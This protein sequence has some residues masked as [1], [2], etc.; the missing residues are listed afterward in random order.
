M[1]NKKINRVIMG[2]IILILVLF[3]LIVFI[4]NYTKDDSSFSIVEKK[5][6]TSNV[7]NII[8]VSIYND[9][10]VYGYNG[11]GISFSF[12]DA[13][14]E[15]NN[16]KFN[17]ISYYSS[18]DVE[19]KDMAFRVLE[20]NESLSSND[21][22][23]YADDYVV[24]N[25]NSD[26]VSSL[27]EIDNIGILNSDEEVIKDY[28]GDKKYVSYENID[29][30]V[31]GLINKEIN[32]FIV[33]NVMYSRQILANDLDIVYHISDLTKKYVLRVKDDTMYNI[34]KKYY[35]KYISEDYID[36]YSDE[37]LDIYFSSTNTSDLLRKNY[38]SKIYKYGYVINMPY[39]DYSNN[40]FVGT[41]SNYLSDFSKTIN[42][43]IEVV[44]YNTIDD[45]KNA[46]VN[47]DVDFALTNFDYQNINMDN[48]TT[49]AFT[50]ED[51]VV[52]STE[53]KVITTLKGLRNEDV[54]VVGSS[55]LHYL[56]LSEDINPVV[57][58]DT[59]DLIRNVNDDSI[60][61]ID[62]GTY[63]Y[64]KNDKL[65]GYKVVYEDTIDDAIKFIVNKDNETFYDLLNYY[66]SSR[67][68]RNIR[69]DYNTDVMI[70]N[71]NDSLKNAII[72]IVGIISVIV[73]ALVIHN[74]KVK[75]MGLSKEDR[76]K[77][78][79]LMTSL[80][81]RNY[82]N[83]NI[84]KW[85]DNV[86]FPQ[87]VIVFDINGVKE[88]NDKFGREVGDEIIKK[89]ASILINNQLENTEI[90]RS[91]GDEFLIYMV[92]YDKDSVVEYSKKLSREMKKIP[93]STG[94]A[95]GYSMILDEVKSV[96]DAINEAI[97]M[98]EKSKSKNR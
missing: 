61:L 35:Y 81:N 39:E 33:P 28:L 16:I 46:L 59:N 60:V 55:N 86:I 37:Y 17:K 69:Y 42:V 98:M 30:L 76:I 73:V 36:D 88:I 44:R 8:D 80:K 27:D 75:S 45:L 77:Y 95:V 48:Y 32:Y 13:F 38:N 50:N 53:N 7:N 83:H 84:Y 19:Y 68:Y 21:I 25:N 29:S 40:N 26:L 97:I 94:S 85:D 47:G 67:D 62:K 58:D 23:F 3:C 71:D 6:I 11:R 31:R 56:C 18:D 82:L 90:I 2:S 49:L 93:N 43:D 54:S 15:D 14:T 34:M 51:Y 22:L 4:F 1:K 87:S 41:I 24:I 5:W 12:L 65:A 20:S 9:I 91:G 66:V 74:R 79:D 63:T 96:D 72:I 10:P 64:Y 52:L 57:F 70:E 92:G 89:V 78:I